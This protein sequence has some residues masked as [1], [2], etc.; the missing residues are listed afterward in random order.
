MKFFTIIVISIFLF[1]NII[2]AETL[3]ITDMR[4]ITF[5]TGP[6]NDHKIIAM[7]KS[8][9]KVQIIQ[10]GDKW[11]EVK[12]AN[13]KQGWVLNRF[14]TKKEP[15]SISILKLKNNYEKVIAQNT[16]L[17][18]K[19]EKLQKDNSRYLEELVKSKSELS[20]I[21]QSYNTLKNDAAGFMDLKAK[22]AK[23][24]SDLDEMTE[25]IKKIKKELAK[26]KMDNTIKWF[27]S[28]AGVLLIG[29]VIGLLFKRKRKSSSFIG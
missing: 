5:R 9:Q 11:T 8:G 14:V 18:N 3:Y 15:S 12:L 24:A 13:G 16:L 26:Y 7:I 1:F 23:T 25:N 17:S 2:Y 29:F 10:P 28:G 21:A 27:V 22:Y 4:R 19:H 20:K 6:G